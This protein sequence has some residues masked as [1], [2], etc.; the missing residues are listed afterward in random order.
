MENKSVKF[1]QK[2]LN[3]EFSLRLT[4]SV[5]DPPVSPARTEQSFFSRLVWSVSRVGTGQEQVRHRER[6]QESPGRTPH[7]GRV[8]GTTPQPGVEG[9]LQ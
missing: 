3:L 6:H 4:Q 9:G 1:C 2:S 5:V 8:D 7:G